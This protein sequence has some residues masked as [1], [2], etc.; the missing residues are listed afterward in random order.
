MQVQLL[1]HRVTE[2]QR[3]KG[4]EWVLRFISGDYAGAEE[5][6]ML[7]CRWRVEVLRC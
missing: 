5:E 7:R 4:A 6:Q 2:L 3:C 1:R